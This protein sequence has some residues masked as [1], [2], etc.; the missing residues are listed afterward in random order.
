MVFALLSMFVGQAQAID[1]NC[2]TTTNLSIY[3]C[4]FRS[5]DWYAS[6][7]GIVDE[8]DA[9]ARTAKSSFTVTGILKAD[10]EVFTSSG[11]WT[12]T[13]T[14]FSAN[15]SVVASFVRIG[16]LVKAE[17]GVTAHGTS[18]STALTVTLPFAARSNMAYSVQVNDSGV[19]QYG[20]CQTG[21]ASATVDCYANA[22][23]AG[24][25]AS[26]TKG[27]WL[28]ITYIMNY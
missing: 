23:F 18:N 27:I 5:S 1:A 9:L 17:L 19:N 6:Y 14:G 3:R 16:N 15:P 12:P 24:W 2:T 8:L 13:W 21:P 28:G 26:G 4:P 20:I 25:T 22:A 7:T 10:S 11:T